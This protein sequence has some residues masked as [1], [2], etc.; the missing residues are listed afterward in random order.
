MFA[1]THSAKLISYRVCRCAK[2]THARL[3]WG[4]FVLYQIRLS[5]QIRK[6]ENNPHECMDSHET[7]EYPDKAHLL[8]RL[9][10]APLQS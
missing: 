3:A 10:H 6:L 2:R 7:C 9:L 5:N 1:K 8:L 4:Q